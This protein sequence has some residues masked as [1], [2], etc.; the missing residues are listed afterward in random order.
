VYTEDL[1][2]LR[3]LNRILNIEWT[4]CD[5]SLLRSKIGFVVDYPNFEAA[6]FWSKNIAI[7]DRPSSWITN[8]VLLENKHL[9]Q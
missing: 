4:D 9:N 3:N 5:A 1:A 8:T 7:L 2:E 6:L